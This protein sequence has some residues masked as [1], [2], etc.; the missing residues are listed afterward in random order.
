MKKGLVLEGGAMRGLFSAG[1]MDAFL[2]NDIAFDGVI[3]VSAGAAFGC[4]YVSGQKGRVLRYNTRFSKDKRYCSLR[5]L[6]KTGDLYNADF[7]YHDIPERLDVFDSEAFLH[8][9]A[10]FIV[11]CTDVLTG[12]PVYQKLEKMDYTDLEW[13]RASASMPLASKIVRIDSFR[14]LDGGI[15]DAIPVKHFEESGYDRNVVILTRP[16]GYAKTKTKF[17]PL[18]KIAFRKYP[19]FIDAVERRHEVYNETLEHIRQKEKQ[20]D[21]IAIR[22]AE[23]LPIGKIEHSADKMRA[24][25]AIGYQAGL[26]YAGQVKEFLKG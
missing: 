15:A 18:F 17:M 24:V 21:L 5:S 2:E 4:N 9:P 12:R 13:L 7:C 22:P 11:V 25:H 1:V 3:G 14:L 20:G 6:I 16:E 10:E 8:N 23:A 26:K 19:K